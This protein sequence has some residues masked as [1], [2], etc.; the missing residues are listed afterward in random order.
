MYPPAWY[1][2]L[3]STLSAA[4]AR[5]ARPLEL[6]M[7]PPAVPAAI[8]KIETALT[9]PLPAEL[10]SVFTDSFRSLGFRWHLDQRADVPMPFASWGGCQISLDDLPELEARRL[11]WIQHAFPNPADPYDAIWHNKFAFMR[12]A[13]GDLIA[14]DA[15]EG[16]SGSV[17]YLSHD[18][19]ALHGATL[20]PSLDEF[21]HRWAAIGCQGPEHW[22]L[23]PYMGSGGLDPNCPNAVQW[24]KWFGLS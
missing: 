15:N 13:N 22:C 17:V 14:V 6:T 11:R 3:E 5:G 24:R 9:S 8:V 20:A 2:M 7:Q 18:D 4:G 10:H 1:P 19:A 16:G 21:L 23:E 12:V